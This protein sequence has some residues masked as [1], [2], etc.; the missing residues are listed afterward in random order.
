M[1]F[2][3]VVLV[4]SQR[5]CIL[6]FCQC[7]RDWDYDDSR[8]LVEVVAELL[9]KYRHHQQTLVER[10]SRLSFDFNSLVLQEEITPADVEIMFSKNEVKYL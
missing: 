1:T 4:S 8:S 5:Y 2:F 10:N 3:V 7:L 9:E 6:I